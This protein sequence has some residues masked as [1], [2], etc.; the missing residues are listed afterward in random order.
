MDLNHHKIY[1]TGVISLIHQ[2]KDETGSKQVIFQ[3]GGRFVPSSQFTIEGKK[4]IRRTMARELYS[5]NLETVHCMV[6]YQ[7]HLGE[8]YANKS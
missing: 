3:S 1:S 4:K 6:Q 7:W 8:L 2:H 5:N